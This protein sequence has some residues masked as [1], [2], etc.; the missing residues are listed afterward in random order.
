M[1]KKNKIF[2]LHEFGLV[3]L[4]NLNRIDI[5][6]KIVLIPIQPMVFRYGFDSDNA[7]HT[8]AY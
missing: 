1:K 8:F 2:E 6:R 7:N 5:F 3:L 4:K